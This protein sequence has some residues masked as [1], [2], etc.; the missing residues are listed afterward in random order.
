MNTRKLRN[1]AFSF[2]RYV[3]LAVGL[4]LVIVG[5]TGS[6]LVFNHEINVALVK[7]KYERVIPRSQTLSLDAIANSVNQTY[8]NQSDYKIHQFDLHFD[9]DIYKVRLINSESKQLEV[10][11]NAYTGKILGDLSR[12]KA[13]FDKVYS[14]HYQLFAGDIGTII[15]GVAALLLFFLTVTGLILWNGWRNF[16]AGFKIKLNASNKR[17]HYDIH[18]VSGI[19]ALVFLAMISISGFVWNF[20][21]QSQPAI[22]N[23]TFSPQ[24]P[25]VKSTPTNN[26][27]IAIAEVLKQAN[28]TIPQAKASF[29]SIPTQPEEV[30]TVYMKQPE[31][32]QY[33][34]NNVQIDRY[35]G[36]VLY[37]INSKTASL[38]DRVLNAFAPMHYGTFGGL[39]T[40]IFYVFIGL[41]P[42][43]LFITGL[44]MYRLRR[45]PQA[46]KQPPKELAER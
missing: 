31:D 9:P 26:K 44:I 11:V 3:G 13:F 34:A 46:V 32:A 10:F 2:H 35:S 12:D 5:L 43:V 27:T 25:E 20:Y 15:V 24:P 6:L 45:R 39:A 1:L 18:K 14:I 28:A 16:L 4:I 29:I 41:S 37:F 42:T 19:I 30:F 33:F 21:D 22:Y 38:G 23:L 7:Q 40:R 36:E 8:A 17:R